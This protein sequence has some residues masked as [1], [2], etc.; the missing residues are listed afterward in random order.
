M[1]WP[2]RRPSPAPHRGCGGSGPRSTLPVGRRVTAALVLTIAAIGLVG[3]SG[4]GETGSAGSSGSSGKGNGNGTVIRVPAD[5]PT[6]QAAVDVARPGSLVL[7]APGTYHEAVK[8]TRAGITVR[9]EDR[10]TVILD[11]QYQKD[12]GFSVGADGVAIENL[13]VRGYNTNGVYFS[14]TAGKEVDPGRVYGTGDDVVKGWRVSYVTTYNDGLY[15][16]YAFAAR[17]GQIDHSYASGHPD[18]GIYI[19]QCKP[20]DA[21][22]T[23]SIAEA[24]AIGYYGTNASGGVYVVNSIFR[25]NRIG[26]TPNSQKMEKLA[27]QAETVV[28]GNLVIDNDNPTSPAVQRGAFGAGI[29]VGGGTK[30]TVVRNRVEG[31]AGVGIM[32]SDLDDYAPANN[33]VEGNVTAGNGVDLV[34]A[35]PAGTGPVG[36]CFTGNTFQ[37]SRPDRIEQALPCDGSGPSGAPVAPFAYPPA[38]PGVDPRSMAA[39]PPQPSMADAA[40]APFQAVVPV[41][42][43]VDVAAIAVPVKTP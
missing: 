18:S 9:G 36:N 39:P 20:C 5:R 32:I 37:S 3:C 29:V 13:S 12:N 35:M 26:L 10:N 27:P 22:V 1:L 33:R 7:V 30:N 42:P 2:R 43:V 40:T 15:G 14:G 31:N 4:R 34:Y 11:G 16:I 28:A 19:G 8:I 17:Y 41:A 24:N 23:D 6:I 38:P 25:G 21:V